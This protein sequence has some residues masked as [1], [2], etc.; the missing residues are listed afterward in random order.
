M[1]YLILFSTTCVKIPQISET[2]SHFSQQNSSVFFQH[3]HYIHFY[4]RSPSKC[5]FSDFPLLALK[6]TKFPLSFFTQRVSFLSK[7]GSV[8][9]FM[10]DN[11]SVLFQLKLY[12]LMTKVA[13]QRANFQA[14]LYAFIMSRTSFRVNLHSI[15]CLNVK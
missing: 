10:R 11:S 1:T 4:K 13:H 2:I 5:K 3:K 12:I 7:F 8:F 9:S 14:C 15:A 6:Y